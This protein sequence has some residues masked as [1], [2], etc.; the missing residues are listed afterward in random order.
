MK[1][2]FYLFIAITLF[3]SCAGTIN[4]VRHTSEKPEY[5]RAVI[6]SAQ[7]SQYIQFKFGTFIGPGLYVPPTTDPSA[8]KHEIIGNTDEVIRKELEKYGISAEIIREGAVPDDFDLL[9]EYYDTWRWDLKNILDKLEIVFISP[10]GEVIATS[11][12]NIYKNKEFHNFP[13]PEKE[14]PKMIKELLEK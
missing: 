5:K 3:T 12:Y 4:T 7:N 2:S 1:K 9:V 13:L 6:I 14:V 10:K 11:T 8:I